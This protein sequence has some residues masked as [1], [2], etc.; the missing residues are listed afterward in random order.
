[1]TLCKHAGEPRSSA[2]TQA[3]GR[4]N[5]IYT[6]YNAIQIQYTYVKIRN[7]YLIIDVVNT[8]A[9]DALRQQGLQRTPWDL[10]RWKVGTS[11][12]QKIA[13]RVRKSWQSPKEI[14]HL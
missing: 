11:L 4:L 14:V 7:V 6:K 5:M 8:S 10:V 2:E 12:K 3:S 1:M 9:V 13:K